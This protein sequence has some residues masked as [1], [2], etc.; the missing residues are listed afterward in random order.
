MYVELGTDESASATLKFTF[1]ATTAM[2]TYEVKVT[3]YRCDSPV[4]PPEGCLQYHTGME[5][6][7]T[8]FNW[9]GQDGHLQNQN[10]KI[11]IR[12]EMGYCCN[13]Y[14]IC[15]NTIFEISSLVVEDGT[16]LDVAATDSL[17]STDHILIES[18]SAD[19]SLTFPTSKYCGGIF[20][21]FVGG[22]VSQAIVGKFVSNYFA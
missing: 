9:E 1:A 5:G 13:K 10:Y 12:Q 6:R 8:T 14:S 7:F 18:S 21:D 16:P 17:C 19:G 3:Q 20:T 11:C 22:E 2:R 15:D 4:R